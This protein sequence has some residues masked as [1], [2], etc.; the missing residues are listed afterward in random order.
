MSDYTKIYDGVTKDLNKST[1]SGADFDVEFAN[2]QT[3]DNSKVDKESAQTITGAKTFT[4]DVDGV[5][6]L[7]LL[8]P[9]GYIYQSTVNTSPQAALGGTWTSL[10]GMVLMAEDGTTGYVAGNTGGSKDA[11]VPTHS[12][13]VTGTAASAGTHN[14]DIK[15]ASVNTSSTNYQA[16]I[17][18]G[19]ST[20]DY[21]HTLGVQ[22]DGAHTHSVTGTAITTGSALANANMPPYKAV[23]MWERTA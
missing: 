16:G 10:R 12:H 8:Y 14:H 3:S 23:Y 22:D 7:D 1:I 11:I 9:V 2:I 15:S 20:P 21:T 19:N 13:S 6:F 18:G 17:S 5:G 4:G